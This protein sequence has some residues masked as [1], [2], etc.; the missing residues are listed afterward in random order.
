MINAEQTF[1]FLITPQEV[2]YTKKCRI[3]NLLSCILNTAGLAAANH[4]FGVPQLVP[5]GLAWVLSRF[6]VEIFDFPTK[7]E[8]ISVQ[9]WIE[10][11]NKLVSSRSMQVVDKNGK[12]LAKASSL[13]AVI[14]VQTRR[15]VNILETLDLKNFAAGSLHDVKPA[16]KI[17]PFEGQ[18][19]KKHRVVYSDTDFNKHVNSVK[20]IEWVVDTYDLE[21][22]AKKQIKTIHV[23]YLQEAMFGEEV[24]ILSA[25][26]NGQDYFEIQNAQQKTSSRIQIEWQNNM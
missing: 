13:W 12:P 15:P 3:T 2:D 1:D 24:C 16:C 23:N 18:C 8:N 7:Y 25:T 22:F 20:Y 11:V 9:T 19:L 21:R 10:D 26:C 14:D 4:G 6:S 5:R 17:E